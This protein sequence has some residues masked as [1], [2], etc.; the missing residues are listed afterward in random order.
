M[1]VGEAG[2]ERL[3]KRE[4]FFGRGE[5]RGDDALMVVF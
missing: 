4:I 3:F 5:N 2:G 1:E